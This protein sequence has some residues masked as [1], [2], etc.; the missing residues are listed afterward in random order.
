M[1][2]WWPRFGAGPAPDPPSQRM[3]LVLT[4]AGAALEFTGIVLVASPSSSHA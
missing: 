4:I 2:T 1:T 3:K